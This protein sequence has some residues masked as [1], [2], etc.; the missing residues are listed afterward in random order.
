MYRIYRTNQNRHYFVATAVIY[1]PCFIYPWLRTAFEYGITRRAYIHIEENGFVRLTIPS[2]NMR[3]KPGQHCFL[4]FTSF[5]LQAL[6]SHPFT[7][8]SL[9]SL[10][11]HESSELVFYIRHSHGLTKRLYDYVQNHPDAAVP[12]LIDGPY[13]GV[14]MQR[15][16]EA[17]RLLVV[18]GGSGAGWILS[19]LELFHRQ[20]SVADVTAGALQK[21]P[22]IEDEETQSKRHSRPRSLRIVLATRDTSSRTWFLSTVAELLAKYPISSESDDVAIEV[23]LT[24]EAERN[25][26]TLGQTDT[27]RI[28]SSSSDNIK[29]ETKGDRTVVAPSQELSGRPDLPLIIHEE[30][31]TAATEGN[32]LAVYIC[33]PAAMQHDVRNAVAKQNLS[34]LSGSMTGGVYLHTEHFSWA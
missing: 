30:G 21:V 27:E 18:A 22:R 13:G 28:S 5:G 15:F 17:D 12:V 2:I 6:S 20:R 10:Q 33:G 34:I 8:C 23:H 9:P 7:I 29:V 31:E 25:V 26:S 24:G 11:A 14:N 16:N 3:W 4:R 32:S 19:L 1:V